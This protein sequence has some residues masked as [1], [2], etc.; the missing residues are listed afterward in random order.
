[1]FIV[2][3]KRTVEHLF[4]QG[5]EV[6]YL[7]CDTAPLTLVFVNENREGKYSQLIIGE[8]KEKTWNEIGLLKIEY[9]I[10]EHPIAPMPPVATANGS[11]SEER[12]GL[13]GRRRTGE[14]TH[15]KGVG[16]Y[17]SR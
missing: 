15:L 9:T 7:F 4:L 1:M 11:M 16:W 2:V 17:V 5:R 6:E 8:S 12:I 13:F 10:V 14:K 3:D